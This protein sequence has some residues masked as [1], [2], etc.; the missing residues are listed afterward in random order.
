[1][2]VIQ[3]EKITKSFKG[4]TLFENVNAT[5]DAGKIYGIVGHNGSG[6]SVLFKLICGFIVP[7]SGT[8]TIDPTYMSKNRTFPENFGVIIDRPGYLPQKTGLDN[9]RDLA[10]IRA[11]IGDDEIRT[12]M[13]SVGL[14]PDTKQAV[15]NY[16]L[17]MKQKLALTQAIMEEPQVL[18][19]DEPFNALD[20]DSVELVRNLLASY[21]DKGR[22]VIF[23]SHNREDM[24]LLADH[25]F[26]IRA[27]SLEQ[28]A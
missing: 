7:D 2:A 18:L 27:N 22:T 6:K 17:G 13:K 3:L 16:S 15:R 26:R 10:R 21:R 8:V 4:T 23:T 28:T 11:V 12:A 25:V 14:A 9:L 20:V 1:M 24:D 19:L 5:F